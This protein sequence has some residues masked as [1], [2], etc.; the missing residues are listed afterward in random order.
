MLNKKQ[1]LELSFRTLLA[2]RQEHLMQLTHWL[3]PTEEELAYL[4]SEYLRISKDTTRVCMLVKDCGRV[5]LFVNKV[6]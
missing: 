6:A 1:N 5:A 2:A 3:E 4:S